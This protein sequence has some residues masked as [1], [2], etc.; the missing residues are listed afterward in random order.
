[1]ISKPCQAAPEKAD[2]TDEEPR[3][4][5]FDGSLAALGE[6]LAS[7]EP[8]AFYFHHPSAGQYLEAVGA[9]ATLNHFQCERAGPFKRYVQLR[10]HMTDIGQLV[11][12]PTSF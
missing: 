8:S 2:L 7:S 12:S 3:L 4:R 9:I 1:M 5:R 11:K 6:G 10:P